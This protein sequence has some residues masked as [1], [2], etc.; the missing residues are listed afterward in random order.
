MYI[1]SLGK[2]CTA[3]ESE[4]GR[5]RGL[6]QVI[7]YSLKIICIT[8]RLDTIKWHGCSNLLTSPNDSCSRTHSGDTYL[9]DLKRS[10]LAIVIKICAN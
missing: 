2:Y 9:L 7:L 3:K 8:F 5:W 6:Y 10:I 4:F 1:S